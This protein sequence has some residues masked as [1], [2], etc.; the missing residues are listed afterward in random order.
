MLDTR[1]QKCLNFALDCC[2]GMWNL[3]WYLPNHY[4]DNI[5]LYGLISL[6]NHSAF[7]S[8]CKWMSPPSIIK[9]SLTNNTCCWNQIMSKILRASEP[10][11]CL[12]VNIIGESSNLNLN[13][14][15]WSFELYLWT[16]WTHWT[17]VPTE[18]VEPCEPTEPFEPVELVEQGSTI[19]LN[20]AF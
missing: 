7:I 12:I 2:D 8:K 14:W 13:L 9:C 17:C 16:L 11:Y 4:L 6:H 10:T 5:S 20:A 3:T 19:P 15:N 1:F 18:L